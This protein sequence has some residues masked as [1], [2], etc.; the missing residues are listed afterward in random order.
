MSK[1]LLPYRY[2]IKLNING[3]MYVFVQSQSFPCDTGSQ[4]KSVLNFSKLALNW[5]F[6]SK[7]EK[8]AGKGG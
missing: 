3:K 8:I 5:K 1:M 4:K 6:H 2:E 7:M